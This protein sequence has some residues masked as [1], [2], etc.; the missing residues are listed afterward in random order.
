V[1]RP[2]HMVRAPRVEGPVLY[3]MATRTQ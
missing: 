1:T 3:E 2:F